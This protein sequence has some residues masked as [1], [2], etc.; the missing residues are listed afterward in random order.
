MPDFVWTIGSFVFFTALVGVISWYLTRKD[1]LSTNTGYFLAG[2]SL[3]G[4]VICGSLILTN[5][6][7]EQLIGLNGNGFMSGISSMSWEVTSGFTLV[8]MA[9]IFL[10]R[11]LKGGFTTIPEYLERRYDRQTRNIVT[12][13]FLLSLVLVTLPIVLY[14]GGI[15]MN[16]LF[17]VSEILGISEDESLNLVIL[18]SGVIGGLYAIFGGLKAVAVSDTINGIG[19]LI[20]GL[21]IPVLGLMALGDGSVLSGMDVLITQYPEKMNAIGDEKASTPFATIFTG[22]LLVNTFYWCTNQQIVQR[23]FAAKNLVEGQKG[24]LIA[25]FIKLCVPFILLI[26][27]II[28]Y[29][30]YKDEIGRQDMAYAILVNHVLPLPLVGFF[31]AVLLGAVLS[32][33][34]SALNS[35]STMFCLNLYKPLFAPQISDRKLVTVG[36]IFG[37]VLVVFSVFIAPYI[38]RA[39]EGLYTFMRSI[40]GF[41]NIPILAVVLVGFFSHRIPPV[42]AKVAIAF[43][44]ICYALYKFVFDI[45]VHYLHVYGILFAC[46]VL[47]MYVFGRIAPMEKPYYDYEARVVDLT[48][49]VWA[50]AG[51]A[52]IITSTIYIYTLFSPVG[53]VG[54]GT[55]YGLR[56]LVITLIYA[57]LTAVLVM[58]FYLRDRKLI[59]THKGRNVHVDNQLAAV[60]G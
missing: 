38:A 27:G 31:G 32:T 12:G 50:R 59:A 23:T 2:R 13:L 48:P 25:G 55:E 5:L 46:C 20:G 10:P 28:A 44:M 24:V 56:L 16:S 11:Y 7:A 51:S 47:I 22:I 45:P 53:I 15:A 60:K 3:S 54:Y 1:N 18:L 43:F 35:A 6:S 52:F 41:F 57:A 34:D 36:K 37:I 42:G 8:L 26:P 40:M 33:F 19:L 29:V 14:A 30:L 17:N 49:W 58:G 4:I 39:P 21:L 9:L